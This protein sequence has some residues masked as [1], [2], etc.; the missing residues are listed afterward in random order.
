MQGGRRER[1]P[2]LGGRNFIES[3]V[4][5]LTYLS[6]QYKLETG[7][8]ML[9]F[10]VVELERHLCGL[11]R[12]M[13]QVKVLYHKNIREAMKEEF[14]DYPV[15][16]LGPSCSVYGILEKWFDENEEKIF[17]DY[18]YLESPDTIGAK[19]KQILNM[20]VYQAIMGALY[21]SGVISST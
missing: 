14:P 4:Y 21:K 12:A 10:L 6:F 9:E 3:I 11:A 17:K 7:R 8:D 15:P 1:V 19:K 18:I 5:T 16:E 13:P 2:F 20:I